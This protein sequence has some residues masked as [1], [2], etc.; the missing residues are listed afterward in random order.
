MADR[1]S[2]REQRAVQ[3]EARLAYGRSVL[4][5][6]AAADLMR[7]FYRQFMP[8]PDK[9]SWLPLEGSR[10]DRERHDF[11]AAAFAYWSMKGFVLPMDRRGYGTD[12]LAFRLSENGR[13]VVLTARKLEGIE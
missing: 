10:T 4:D 1:P 13:T 7:E 11:L 8:D 9:I 2:R 12:Q 3:R 6:F 5:R